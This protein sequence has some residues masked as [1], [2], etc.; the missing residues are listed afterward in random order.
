MAPKIPGKF[1]EM[2]WHQ[3][4][5]IKHFEVIKMF[6]SASNKY[7]LLF[8]NRKSNHKNTKSY[9]ELLRGLLS[10][11]KLV[12]YLET[13]CNGTNATKQLQSYILF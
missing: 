8:E 13:R 1:L 11:F 2:F 7:I 10:Y 9:R 12:F 4:T 6:L 5:Q 3:Q